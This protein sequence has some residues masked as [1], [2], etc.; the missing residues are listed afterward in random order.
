MKTV[1]LLFDSLNRLMLEPYGGEVLKTPNF[2]RLAERCITFDN[3][4]IGSMP[5]MPARRDMQTGRHTFLHRS[6]G[7]LEPFDNSFPELLKTAG[8][9]SQL[10]S[11]HY[12][13]WE[14]GGATYHNRF[15]TFEFFRGQEGDPWKGHVADPDIPKSVSW[16]AGRLWRQDWINRG[17]TGTKETHSQTLTVNAGLEFITTNRGQDNWFLQIECFD[18]HEPF[19]TPGP[20]NPTAEGYD[21]DHFDWPD[22][23][24]VMED[25]KT[26]AHLRKGYGTLLKMCDA[27]LGRVLDLMDA[28]GMWDDTM[29]IV[30]TDHGF[31]L[32]ERGWY[33]KNVQPWYEENIHTPLFLWDPRH[34]IANE[35][36]SA[37]VQTVDF[38]PTLLEFFGLPLTPDMQGRPL[39]PAVQTDQPIRDTALFGVHGGHVCLTDGRYVYM[40]SCATPANAPLEEFTLMPTRID[41]RFAVA[42][43][44]D[45]ELH[46]PLPFTKSVPVLRTTGRAMGNPYHFGTLLY[47]L[48]ADPDQLAPIRDPALERD[49][50][51]KLLVALRASDAPPSQFARLG[52]P[53]TGPL[54]DE[55]LLVERQWS[56]V[57]ASLARNWKVAP[58]S[59]FD[60]RF[61]LPLTEFCADPALARQTSQTLGVPLSGPLMER[62]GHLTLWQLCVMLPGITPDKLHALGQTLS[63]ETT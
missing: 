42:D 54:A 29:L 19:F 9:Y 37:L 31:L 24:P 62:F 39:A 41:H 32:G 18:P 26:V 14:D 8:A 10:I 23:R 35:R 57:Q 25:D 45:A 22:Y 13:Y 2:R 11:D 33:G 52:L 48:Q 1:F 60:P 20:E 30:C 40:R 46:P 51:E 21:G 7:P 38:G 16:R 56:Q 58:A 61:S 59:D 27:S 36:R 49:M 3:H 12:H 5:C 15:S 53:E 50:A 63:C 47:D 34:R 28:D 6:W 55:H 4:Y 44:V 43:L 17:Y